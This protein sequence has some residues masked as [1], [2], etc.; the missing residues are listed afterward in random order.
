M[1]VYLCVSVSAQLILC[2]SV[3]E[4]F[5][6]F[7]CAFVQTVC[8]YV[9]CVCAV[10]VNVCVHAVECHSVLMLGVCSQVLVLYMS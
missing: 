1:A 4:C 9:V 2:V 8:V 5:C 7:T 3:R 10:S 6:V